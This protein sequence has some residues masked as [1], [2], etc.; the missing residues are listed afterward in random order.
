MQRFRPRTPLGWTIAAFGFLVFCGLC[1][2]VRQSLG[3]IPP[4]E[5]TAVV[6]ATAAPPTEE[7]AAAPTEA[8]TEVPAAPAD[9]YASGALGLSQEAVE[10]ER[11][12]ATREASGIQFYAGDVSIIYLGGRAWQVEQSLSP[13]AELEAARATA[14]ELLPAD[15]EL[16][17]T[18]TAASGATVDRYR[19]ASLAERFPDDGWVGGEPGDHVVIYRADDRGV[20][21]LVVGTG[22]NP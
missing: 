11:G 5:P 4:I 21:G 10:A 2:I 3:L 13:P 20:F 8:P 19:S 15:A 9:D 6:V 22:N 17:E 1:A 12:Q 16:I 7:P 18:Y 14:R